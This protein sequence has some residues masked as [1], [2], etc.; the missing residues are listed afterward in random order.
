MPPIRPKPRVGRK[1]RREGGVMIQC[2]TCKTPGIIISAPIYHTVYLD[3]DENV[4]DYEQSGDIEYDSTVD[5]NCP[6]CGW[7][8]QLKHTYADDN[9]PDA[10]QPDESAQYRQEAKDRYHDEGTIEVDDNAT[11]SQ[12][13]DGAYVQAWVWAPKPNV[14]E[15]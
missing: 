6:L 8:G 1:H 3:Q 9:Q 12:S 13:D 2:P 10:N 15:E 11:V 14:E 4:T 5:A 7:N